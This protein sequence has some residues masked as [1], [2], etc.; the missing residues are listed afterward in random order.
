MSAA[1][2]PNPRENWNKPGLDAFEV[3]GS[4]AQPG[5]KPTGTKSRGLASSMPETSPLDEM[6]SPAYKAPSALNWLGSQEYQ[7]EANYSRTAPIDDVLNSRS[8]RPLTLS[9][10]LSDSKHPTALD[11]LGSQEYQADSNY[12]RK[13]KADDELGQLETE[14]DSGLINPKKALSFV[15]DYQSAP[16]FYRNSVTYDS[17]SPQYNPV[18]GRLT[19]H[20]KDL[21]ERAEIRAFEASHAPPT[22]FDRRQAHALNNQEYDAV[23]HS[24]LHKIAG[25]FWHENNADANQTSPRNLTANMAAAPTYRPS[26][27]PASPGLLRPVGRFET[28][29]VP[30]RDLTNPEIGQ[31]DTTFFG[32]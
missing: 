23:S 18:H 6:F 1:T 21:R 10:P 28:K 31:V 32:N 8:Q 15:P 27:A 14:V 20:A 3:I 26:A 22:V 13:A 12:P 5:D 17:M 29:P 9:T 25:F 30:G 11:W 19:D 2:N 7:A 16:P 24:W 4:H